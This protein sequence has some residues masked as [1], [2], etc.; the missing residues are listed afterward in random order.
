MD[1]IVALPV[2]STSADACA[3]FVDRFSKMAHFLPCQTTTT[4]ERL[5]QLF[6]KHIYRLHGLPLS[7]VSDRDPKLTSQFWQELMMQLGTK[8]KLSTAYHPQTD[9]QTERTNRTIEEMLRCFVS[10]TPALWEETMPMLEFCYNDS[11]HASTGYSPFFLC[12]GRHP[13]TAASLLKSPLP[14]TASPSA[15]QALYKLQTAVSNARK[16]I[17]C[18]QDQQKAYYDRQHRDVS[19]KQ[20]DRVWLSTEHLRPTRQTRHKLMPQWTGPFE[21][22]D[23]VSPVA[24]RLKL[25]PTMNLV[26]PVFPISQ[27]KPVHLRRGARMPT[28]EDVAYQPADSDPAAADDME[29][30]VEE[31][32]EERIQGRGRRRE[33]QFLVKF[34]GYAAPE[35]IPAK[36]VHASQKI[37]DFRAS[38]RP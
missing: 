27:L 5:A 33:R 2:T 35:W 28:T 10:M 31:I 13:R 18:A 37:D 32:L 14:R 26:H 11:V 8:I 6:K 23:V 17:L 34:T 38:Q 3:V 22:L 4:A 12:Y 24:Y 21:I 36:N 7:I 29:Y 15:D 25:P 16:S 9:G 19:F 20:G 30:D 1:L